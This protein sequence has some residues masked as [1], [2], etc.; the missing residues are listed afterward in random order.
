[1]ARPRCGKSLWIP[2]LPELCAPVVIKTT[3]TLCRAELS[4]L[5]SCASRHQPSKL[6]ANPSNRQKEKHNGYCHL[7]ASAD[8]GL[9][10][11]QRLKELCQHRKIS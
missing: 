10:P 6:L 1:M 4:V 3:S 9:L 11:A 5:C 2:A 7:A 8:R